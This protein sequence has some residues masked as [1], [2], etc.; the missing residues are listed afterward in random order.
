MK[1]VSNCK[2]LILNT[3]INSGGQFLGTNDLA[4][5]IN[6]PYSLVKRELAALI[7][8]GLISMPLESVAAQGKRT[9]KKLIKITPAGESAW[10]L[11]N[12]LE[13]E[14]A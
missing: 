1:A 7:A 8:Q 4:R 13:R 2:A 6:K 3:L 11:I 10:A 12:V 14:A 9:P 5:A